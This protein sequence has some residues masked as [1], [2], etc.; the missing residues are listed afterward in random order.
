M[1][2]PMPSRANRKDYGSSHTM[3]RQ[4]W[5][6]WLF[7][8]RAA[9][10]LTRSPALHILKRRGGTIRTSTF[11]SEWAIFSRTAILL[12]FKDSYNAQ[13]QRERRSAMAGSGC[14]LEPPGGFVKHQSS[15]CL[16]TLFCWL[17][18]GSQ[19]GMFNICP[20]FEHGAG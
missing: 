11:F 2:K 15:F 19:I 7:T 16:Q 12:H 14:P 6:I 20:R 10:A 3:E 9:T 5:A 8:T 4:A 18:S 17:G 13:T 1:E